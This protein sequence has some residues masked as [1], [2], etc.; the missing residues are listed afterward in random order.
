MDVI[1]NTTSKN[2]KLKSGA[3]S[4]AIVKAGGPS[5]QAE[6]SASAPNGAP[7]GQIIVTSGGNLQCTRVYHGALVAWD[8]RN[9][10]AK[11]VYH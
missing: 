7:P 10:R 6:I 3:V 1:V 2:F 8:G 11:K 5:L 9:G 4:A